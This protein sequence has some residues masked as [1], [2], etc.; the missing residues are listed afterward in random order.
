MVTLNGLIDQKVINKK[1]REKMDKLIL[2]THLEFKQ[3]YGSIKIA[4][5]LNKR[6]VKVSERTVSRI[7]TK[8][9][10]KSCTVN[11]YKATTNSNHKHPMSD[12]VLDRQFM[13]QSPNKAWV[14]D[15]TYIPTNEG[16]LY[17]TS[18]MEYASKEYQNLLKKYKM[19]GSIEP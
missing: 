8:N 14:T 2:R 15:I 17:L 18:V 19:V 12:N 16:W 13:A 6:G 5:T 4:K 11:K 1:K 3:R 7:M 9:N 10:W